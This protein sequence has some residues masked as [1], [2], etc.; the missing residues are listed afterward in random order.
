MTY[1]EIKNA[2]GAAGIKNCD[3]E[4]RILLEE[5][6]GEALK[7]AVKR[8]ISREPLQ[9]IIGRWDFYK[10]EYFVSPACLIPRSDTEILVDWLIKNLESNSK[11]LDLCTGSGC[12]AIS[13]AKNRPDISAKAADISE[14]AL[15][16]AKKNAM[17][18]GVNSVEFFHTDVTKKPDTTELFDCI[19]SNPPYICS[20]VVAALEPELT[21]EPKIALD[22]G[23]DG[24][25]FYRAIV[26][27][28]KNNLKSG[29]IFAFEFGYDQKDEAHAL[30]K[31]HGF[32]CKEL[33]DYGS[34]F[35]AAIFTK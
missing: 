25:D 20:D 1:S 22:G 32:A 8:R 13:I 18:N 5:F 10:E 3:G 21:H 11:V 34:N 19:V 31:E 24:M 26:E 33:Y 9:Y 15:E 2:L 12:I 30:A 35:R 14:D 4:A 28:Y 7:D 6:E 29:G 23:A 16:I 27:N 17:H